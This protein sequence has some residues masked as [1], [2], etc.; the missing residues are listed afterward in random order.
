MPEFKLRPLIN[1]ASFG[2]GPTSDDYVV[3]CAAELF[4]RNGI[5]NVKMVDIAQAA[6]VGVATVYRHFSTKVAIAV[7][8]ATLLWRR[9]NEQFQRLVESEAF[10]ELNGLLRLKVLLES[11]CVAYTKH[12]D[13]VAFL[14]E[15]DHMVITQGIDADALME[16]NEQ[17]ESFYPIFENAYRLGREDGSIARELNFSEFYLAVA[18]AL[19][20]VAT[21]LV[22]GEVIPSDD[23][24]HPKT[25]LESIVNMAMWSLM[26]TDVMPSSAVSI[27][28][29]E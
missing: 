19:M 2:K 24:S 5:A 25:E 8:A 11:Y 18:H 17:I 20:G 23:F 4:L 29:K 27:D 21:K 1:D 12:H 9:F 26:S 14:D 10:L 15:F 13:F 28:V 22:R 6:D 3:A 7:Q 16:Y